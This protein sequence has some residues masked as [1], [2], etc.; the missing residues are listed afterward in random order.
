MKD[1]PGFKDFKITD[2]NK[3][4]NTKTQ[5]ELKGS[6][7]GSGYRFYHVRNDAGCDLN[8]GEHR[9]IALAYHGPPE[10]E[11]YVVNHKNGLKLDN[12]PENLEWCSYRDNLIHAGQNGLSSKAVSVQVRNIVTRE[13]FEFE[14]MID[15]AN[16]F[17]ITKDT[18]SY[19][20]KQGE[21][22]IFPGALQFRLA[23][24]TPW[25]DSDDIDLILLDKAILVKDLDT[26]EVQPFEKLQ[27]AAKFLGITPGGLTA[28]FKRSPQPVV[29]SKYQLKKTS[30]TNEW[31]EPVNLRVEQPV[32]VTSVRTGEE[33]I[34][35]TAKAAAI[36][37]NLTATAL[38]Y[39][40]GSEGKK[41]F[42]DG[43]TYCRIQTRS[44]IVETQ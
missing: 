24:S 41:V 12:R 22:R 35:A 38:D 15:C 26:Q 37:N 13:V 5:K 14:T 16:N 2:R 39:R 18:V 20:C 4:Y 11:N 33:T 30:D 43:K 9:L 36:A 3:V 42:R 32:K 40:L 25:L 27:D 10:V 28:Y 34:Y 6:I 1:I 23:I 21:L 17:G 31:I 7:N 29:K 8:V 44:A 19:R